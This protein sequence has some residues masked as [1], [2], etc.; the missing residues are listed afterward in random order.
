MLSQGHGR[1]HPARAPSPSTA[2]STEVVAHARDIVRTFDAFENE[3]REVL[4]SVAC[5]APPEMA[6]EIRSLRIESVN[7]NSPGEGM[8]WLTGAA[9]EFRLWRCDYVSGRP[10][11]PGFDD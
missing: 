2:P 5:K 11:G 7:L 9:V 1:E 6:R 8:I 4:E 10:R 3:V